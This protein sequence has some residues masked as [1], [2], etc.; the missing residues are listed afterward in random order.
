MQTFDHDGGGRPQ[1][2]YQAKC[3]RLDIK[4]IFPASEKSASIPANQR[5][6]QIQK[7]RRPIRPLN[8]NNHCCM[9]M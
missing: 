4:Q 3:R 9:V 7:S 6:T 1:Q 8:E 2:T 5:P